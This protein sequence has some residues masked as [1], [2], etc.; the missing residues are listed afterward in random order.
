MYMIHFADMDKQEIQP[1]DPNE[2]FP[3]TIID[4][5][6]YNRNEDITSDLNR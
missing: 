6:D 5:C 4:K 3:G 1:E 2:V